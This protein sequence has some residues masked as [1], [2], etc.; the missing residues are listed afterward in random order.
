MHSKPAD[1]RRGRVV[2]LEKDLSTWTNHDGVPLVS[3]DRP[4]TIPR[5]CVSVSLTQKPLGRS[6]LASARR[7]PL[8]HTVSPAAKRSGRECT[9]KPSRAPA[10]PFEGPPRKSDFRRLPDKTKLACVFFATRTD[11]WRSPGRPCFLTGEVRCSKDFTS[12]PRPP[13]AVWACWTSTTGP[14]RRDGSNSTH[15]ENTDSHVP[16]SPRTNSHERLSR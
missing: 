10:R 11:S 4:S 5:R 9:S 14:D 13:S 3:T 1:D 8:C 2:H 6:M 15:L 12:D 16:V 7:H